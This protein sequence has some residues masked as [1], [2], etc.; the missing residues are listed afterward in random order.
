MSGD[1]VPGDSLA[2][3]SSKEPARFIVGLGASAGGLEA[4]ERFFDKMPPHTGAAFVVIQH[5]SPNFK[6][7]MDEL[8][9]RKTRIPIHRVEHNMEVQ[10]DAIYLIPPKKEMVI[11]EGRLQLTDKEPGQHFSLPIDRFFHSL[12][13]QLQERSIGIIL[14]GT[15]SDGARGVR[16]IRSAGGLVLAQAPS[17]AKFDGMPNSAIQTGA[18]DMILTPEEMPGALLKYIH[19]PD[20][21]LVKPLTSDQEPAEGLEAIYRLL[22][23][24]FGLDFSQYKLGTVKRRI[25]RR[26]LLQECADLDAYILQVEQNSNEL[27]ELYKDL[28]IGVTRFF[29]DPAAFAKLQTEVFPQLLAEHQNQEELRIWVAG[30]ATGEEAYTLGMLIQE[31]QDRLEKRVPVKIFATD[32]HRTSIEFASSGLY[33]AGQLIDVDPERLERH[34]TRRHEH[35]QVGHEL[36]QMVVFAQHNLLKDAPFT[37]VDMVSCRNVLIYFQPPAQRRILSMFHYAL[38]ANGTL[39]LGPSE[40]P[41]DI[42]GEFVSL[43]DHWKMYRKRRDVHLHQ[44]LHG[45]ATLPFISIPPRTSSQRTLASSLTQQQLMSAYDTLLEQFMPPSILLNQNQEVLHIFGDVSRFLSV[46]KGRL[47][48]QIQEMIVPELRVMLNGALHRINVDK[49]PV[50]YKGLRVDHNGSLMVV[51]MTVR[52]LQNDRQSAG[53]ILVIL[54]AD[55]TLSS[56]LPTATEFN[57]T[58]A[59]KD[60]LENLEVELRYTKDNLQSTIE[61]MEA[62]NEELQATNEELIASNEELQSTNEELH[63]VNEELYTVNAEYQKK[64]TE[65]IELT[66][67][68]DNLLQSTEVHTLFL[69][70]RLCIR[71]FTPRIAETFNL[72]EQ[73]IG[74]RIDSFTHG[75]NH[76]ALVDDIRQVMTTGRALEQEVTDQ[77]NRYFLMRILPYRSGNQVDGA[78][79]TLIDITSIKTIEANARAIDQKLT[80]ILRYSPHLVTI[81]DRQGRYLLTDKNFERIVGTDPVGKTSEEL[82]PAE[83]AK[84][85]TLADHRVFKDGVT[86]ENEVMIPLEDGPHTYLAVKF[87]VR[88]EAG[89]IVA[90]GGVKTDVTRLKKAERQA[91]EAVLHR[92]RF[93]A[94]L[95]HE[96]RNPLGAIVNA[97]NVLQDS[98]PQSEPWTEALAVLTRQAEQMK[99]LLDDLL[100]VA[101]ITQEKMTLCPEVV[102]MN[103]IIEETAQG[104]RFAA[105]EA[106]VHL[107]VYLDP[108]PCYLR[109]DRTRLQQML[110]NLIHNAIKYTPRGGSIWLELKHQP[111]RQEITVTVRDN[112]AGIQPYMLDQIFDLFVQADDSLERSSGGLG[113]GLT[114]VRAIA[115]L[116]HGEVFAFSEGSSQ[117]SVFTIKLP[118]LPAKAVAEEVVSKPETRAF[119]SASFGDVLLAVVEDNDDSRRMLET[120]LKMQGYRTVS[121]ADGLL[122]RE[123]IEK[124][125]PHLAFIDIGLPGLNGFEL[126]KQLRS[127][128]ATASLLLIAITGYGRTEDQ[129]AARQAGFDE[130][131]VKPL[132][133]QQLDKILKKYLVARS[134]QHAKRS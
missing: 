91:T 132:Q 53:Q 43:D 18:V 60:Q 71:K 65:L 119:S 92:D 9:A 32:V 76:P 93:L 78:V 130:H 70:N 105:E 48:T 89:Q 25:D 74:R 134:D 100:D 8:L 22:R 36:R 81:K 102:Q 13:E 56:R 123:I 75:I 61:E 26:M 63:S 127:Q 16:D 59:S 117:G 46:R 83:T 112:G 39:F 108:E 116:H 90:V 7:L 115:K 128:P 47:S 34:F 54:E 6:S 131:L 66:A 10:P 101:R 121:A 114:M 111:E 31:C 11:S 125:R 33:A 122:G 67:D 50:V 20:G 35:Y 77:R 64:I 118:L 1:L 41:G 28:L 79:L 80:G 120:M 45:V 4:L 58:Q 5:L 85:M 62:S 82:L 2:S 52:S 72:I 110:A 129:Q 17:S 69:D 113:V 42:S 14:S 87:P 106:G 3:A 98:T 15:G 94:M 38:K 12:A 84:L 40:S 68:M 86:I 88:N 30:C 57:L 21:S 37:K 124:N 99:R 95:S 109:G 133:R 49:S 55:N 107:H 104:M 27:N 103:Q 73:D 23:L 51:N 19:H 44:E 126:A 96:L 29:R 24:K 97:V